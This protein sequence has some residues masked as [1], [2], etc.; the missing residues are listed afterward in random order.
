MSN[1]DMK[2]KQRIED[3]NQQVIL[4]VC[5]GISHSRIVASYE[6]GDIMNEV[7]IKVDGETVKVFPAIN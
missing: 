5:K 7:Q 1:D 4:L 6:G 2:R 3:I